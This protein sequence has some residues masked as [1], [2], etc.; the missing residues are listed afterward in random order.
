M[1]LYMVLNQIT[2]DIIAFRTG[3]YHAMFFLN[4]FDIILYYII[5]FY[6]NISYLIMF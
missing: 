3:C 6:C 4:I 1:I 5:F 2:Y